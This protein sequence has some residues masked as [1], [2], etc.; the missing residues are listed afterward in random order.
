MPGRP[1]KPDESRIRS[2]TPVVGEVS[3]VEVTPLPVSGWLSATKA[4]WAALWDDAIAGAYALAT[5]LPALR[6]L[7][8]LR[9]QRA[10]YAA[11][12][13]KEPLVEGSQGQPVAHPLAKQIPVLDTEIRQLEDRFGLNPQARLRLG[14]K[15]SESQQRI[16]D[17]TADL[18]DDSGDDAD[19]FRVVG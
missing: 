3:A 2:A 18:D 4:E 14:I 8:G 15:F 16:A 19:R 7:F 9:D 6:R 11:A 13:A 12:V 5:D 1:R 10:R 17:L